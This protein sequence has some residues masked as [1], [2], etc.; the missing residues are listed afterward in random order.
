[1]KALSNSGSESEVEA[2]SA[3]FE[4]AS[5]LSA[6]THG[7]MVNDDCIHLTYIVDYLINNGLTI[8]TVNDEREAIE[9][10]ALGHHD[11]STL[12]HVA[13]FVKTWRA[14]KCRT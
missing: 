4:I 6:E 2:V 3:I 14:S 7:C 11:K 13:R 10:I 8:G 5:Q 12:D 1:M 9:A